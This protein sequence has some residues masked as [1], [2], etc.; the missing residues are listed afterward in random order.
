M[1]KFDEMFK[2]IT[3][4]DD[5]VIG[6]RY[7]VVCTGRDWF[8]IDDSDCTF[9]YHSDLGQNVLTVCDSDRYFPKECMDD[10]QGDYM[11][12]IFE[13]LEEDKI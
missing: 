10:S 8:G 5:L 9:D 2:R 1:K 7:H 3:N 12:A 4:W 13:Y 11:I 6:K